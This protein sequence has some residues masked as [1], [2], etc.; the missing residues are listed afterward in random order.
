MEQARDSAQ[1]DEK[2]AAVSPGN[3]VSEQPIRFAGSTL[4][5]YRHVITVATVADALAALERLKVDILISD[6]E[7]PVEDG[8]S[9][10][11]KVR[12]KEGASGGRIS[13]AAL[14]A[15]AGVVDRMR[16]LSAGFDIHVP[17]PVDP[18]ELLAVIASL[19]SRIGPI[20]GQDPA[21]RMVKQP[22]EQRTPTD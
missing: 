9:F 5:A 22:D 16:A 6:I 7:M 17:K 12:A 13:A 15:H 14:T 1:P 19:A 20:R 3:S 8:Y 10:I 11:R 21:A 2:I 18:A 4:G